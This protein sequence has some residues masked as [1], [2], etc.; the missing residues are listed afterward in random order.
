MRT[1]EDGIMG[2][3]RMLCRWTV[4]GVLVLAAACAAPPP[5][6][7]TIGGAAPV[8][9]DEA[10][11]QMAASLSRQLAAQ[12]NVM[13]RLAGMAGKA[14]R[15]VI[16]VD[17]VIDG[18]SGQ[19]TVLAGDFER[20]LVARLRS[21]NAELMVMPLGSDSLRQADLLLVGTI[22]LEGAGST[23]RVPAGS[24]ARAQVSIV[25]RGKALVLAHASARVRNTGL[26]LTPSKL[27][28]DS[29]VVSL[30]RVA[31][32][33]IRT[34]GANGGEAA[35]PRYL[36]ALGAA[37]SIN[38]GKDAYDAGRFAES[39][40]HFQAALEDPTGE[41]LIALNGSYLA[42]IK[43]G[44]LDLAEDHF[45]RIVRLGVTDRN[46]NVRFL[47]NPGT[48]DFWSDPQI[49]GQYEMWIRQ[50]GKG[51]QRAKACVQLVGHASHTGTEEFND[52]LSE[53]RA[54][55]VRQR[56]LQQVP[57]LAPSLT[58]KG[59]GFRKT[60][61]GIGTDDSRDALDR[62]VEFRVHD[63]G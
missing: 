45:G 14:P 1:K 11:A 26:D 35:D 53:Q 25:S 16:A 38:A 36:A 22:T 39:A 6:T 61:V 9:L 54:L 42:S 32:A 18:A 4:L 20:R 24:P 48:T 47:F 41:R 43:L 56:L 33:Q 51:I 40:K 46:L 29:P 13:E 12:S 27:D 28:Q 8:S 21:T 50:V 63:C 55:H 5:N 34:A 44:R 19:R 52:R 10:V 60:L 59:M 31:A 57:Q 62:R 49:S 3:L 30:D 23:M 7:G 15:R 17:T 37:A 58:A 2:S